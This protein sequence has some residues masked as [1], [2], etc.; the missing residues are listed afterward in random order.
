MTPRKLAQFARKR[1]HAILDMSGEVLYSGVST[2]ERGDIYL[3]G[4]N[5]GGDAANPRLPTVRSSLEELPSKC[6]NSYLDTLWSG[7]D[8]LQRRVIWLLAGLGFH[9]TN[10]TASNLIF[11]RSRDAAGS[12]FGQFAEL[13]WPVHEQSLQIVQPRIVVVYGNSSNSPFSFLIQKYGVTRTEAF[14]SGHGDW[15]CRRF[16]VPGRFLVV[17]LPHLSRYDITKHSSVVRWIKD[18]AGP[19]K[20]GAL[21][22]QRRASANK[23]VSLNVITSA[24]PRRKGDSVRYMEGGDMGDLLLRSSSTDPDG[25]IE[26]F[27]P[28]GWRSYM[29]W[30][31]LSYE[32]FLHISTIT[33][34][35][36]RGRIQAVAGLPASEAEAMLIRPRLA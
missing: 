4:H 6:I 10:V 15:L 26:I 8:A 22:A 31:N 33:A 29:R 35:D 23:Q 21:K 36:A 14:P 16:E 27:G 2:L 7:R 24:D 20:A 11:M 19:V 34:E 28:E 30:R 5:P 9:P 25:D 17:G 32:Q 18:G 13:C 3:L 12:Q 1:L